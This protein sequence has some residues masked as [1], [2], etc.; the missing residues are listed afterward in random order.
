MPAQPAAGR[1]RRAPGTGPPRPG[2]AGAR[3]RSGAPRRCWRS[4]SGLGLVIGALFLAASLTPSLIP[5]S[6]LLQGCSPASASRSATAS[7]SLSC[8]L[9]E[10]LELPIAAGGLRRNATW[11]AAAVAALD[12]RQPSPG[13]PRSGRTRSASASTCRRWTART[14]SRSMADR[15]ASSSLVLILLGRLF[16]WVAPRR[17]R[18]GWRATCPSGCSKFVGLVV[19]VA[20]FWRHR[21]RRA[22]AR[23]L[24]RRRRALRQP[25]TR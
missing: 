1:R 19:A 5:R 23:L 3:G 21:R 9:W 6:F 18:A 22:A 16:L 17:P 7:A 11:A 4:F 14:R 15:R 20:L 12:R 13:G 8:W 2:A 10:Y 25:A 24:Q